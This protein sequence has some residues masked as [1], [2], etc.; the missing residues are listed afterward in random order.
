MTIRIGTAP[1]S[2]GIMEVATSS[3][4]TQ[5]FDS[6]LDEMVLAGPNGTEISPWGFLP[7]DPKRLMAELSRRNCV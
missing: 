6:G 7:T 2:W 1:A 5:T 4:R 3:G